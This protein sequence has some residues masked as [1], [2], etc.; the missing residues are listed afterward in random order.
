MKSIQFKNEYGETIEL[1][2]GSTD[3]ILIKHTDIDSNEFGEFVDL[4]PTWELASMTISG[5]KPH[6]EAVKRGG[7]DAIMLFQG[8][9]QILNAEEVK[10]IRE[11]IKSL[12]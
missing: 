12:G 1:K 3:Q 6:L 10:A 7:F 2:R 9:A 4:A 11:A 5:L 8:R